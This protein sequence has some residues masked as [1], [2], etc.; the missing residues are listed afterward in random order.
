MAFVI[1]QNCCTDASCVPVC[2]VD[3]IRPVPDQAGAAAPM[4]YIDPAS[5]VDCGACVAVC[6]VGAI[7]HEDELPESQQRFKTIN[8]DFFATEPLAIRPIPANWTP[9]PVGRD[10][11]RVAVVGAGP[12]ACYAVADLARTTG[13]Q[14]D[15]F[16][17]LPTPFGL[18]R[19]GVAPDH[20]RTKD[21][22]QV[23]ETALA[24]PNVTCFFNVAVGQDVT[25]D[26]LM[27]NHDAVIYAVGAS[28]TRELDIPGEEL[29]G[30]IGA[31]EFV[32]WYN[33]HP[34]HAERRFDLA[35]PRV[36]I[37]GNGNVALDVARVLV[38]D[39]DQLAATDIAEHALHQLAAGDVREVVL[40]GRRGAA[41]GAFSVGELL[42]LGGLPG[43]DVVV[44]GEV[45]E[46]PDDHERA[47]KFDIVG[48]Y[49]QRSST[50]GNKRIVLR[51]GT[52]PVRIVGDDRVRALEVEGGAGV[53]SIDTALVLKSIGYRGTPIEGLPFDEAAGVVPNEG[54][55]VIHD[56]VPVPGVYVTGWIKRGPRGVIG[57]NR[58]CARETVTNLLAD[59]RA[60]TLPDPA[61][62]TGP[63]ASD[64]A[65]HGVTV[66]DLAGW[67]RIDAAE[68]QLGAAASR[69]RVKVVDRRALLT[70]AAVVS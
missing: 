58:L 64:F 47:L 20:Q 55:R 16:D 27:A 56:G 50:A 1:T 44:E 33:G 45:G 8:A 10:T 6:P 15:V 37:V 36:V 65:A 35:G 5:C 42:A 68:R 57:T 22:V 49:A 29:P 51:F 52:R 31:A 24:S 4:L 13:V 39:P 34:D 53:V 59:A 62:Q 11:L 54:G 61:S 2:P 70:A 21:V 40:L 67:R 32:N 14:V 60:G 3:C 69:P 48:E 17:R 63:D 66:V 23:F 41:D 12:A 9:A 25:H 18:V 28:T 30:T 26:Q 19:F 46:R 7:Y 38:M 43:V